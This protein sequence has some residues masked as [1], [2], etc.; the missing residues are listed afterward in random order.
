[1]LLRMF[2][3]YETTPKLHVLCAKNAARL[4]RLMSNQE[5]AATLAAAASSTVDVLY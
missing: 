4:S 3:T 5:F 1:M 2:A